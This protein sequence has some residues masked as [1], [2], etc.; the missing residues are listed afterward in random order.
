MLLYDL[1]GADAGR[2]FSPYCWRIRMSLAHKRLPV[3]TRPWRFTECL[4]S[5]PSMSERPIKL[6]SAAS[7]SRP[8]GVSAVLSL[9]LESAFLDTSICSKM[10]ATR[11]ASIPP[12]ECKIA[13]PVS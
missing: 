12:Q 6:V 2:R 11:D 5:H 13:V 3:E 8:S 9:G 7:S 1:A 4:S 10:L